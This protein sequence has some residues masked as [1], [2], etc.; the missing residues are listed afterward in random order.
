MTVPDFPGPFE[1]SEEVR[2]LPAVRAVYAEMRASSDR[3]VMARCGAGLIEGAVESAG[4]PMG[5]YDQRIAVWVGN[6]GPVESATVAS[7]ITR[8]ARASRPGPHSVV[9]DLAN[10][11]DGGVVYHVLTRALQDFAD[12]ERDIAQGEGGNDIRDRWAQI[13]DRLLGTVEAAVDGDL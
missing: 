3:G 6:F 4:A 8:A 1:S 9:F 13:A 5:T 7:W 2:V 11:N 10:V 12:R